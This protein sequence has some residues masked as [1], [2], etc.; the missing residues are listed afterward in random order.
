MRNMSFAFTTDQI[1][2]GTKTVT[3]RVGWLRLMPG[4]LIRPVRKSMGLR[5]GQRIEPIRG[6]LRVLSVRRERLSALLEDVDY[7]FAETTA[8]GFPSTSEKHWPSVFVEFF[9]ATHN[10]RPTDMVTRIEFEYPP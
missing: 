8:E 1:L 3:R 4:D 2:A 10:C 6:P 7:G 5:R 9:C